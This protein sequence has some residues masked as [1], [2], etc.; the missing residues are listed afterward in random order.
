MESNKAQ[1]LREKNKR[2]AWGLVLIITG[3]VVYSWVVIKVRGKL[4]EPSDETRLQKIL[5]GL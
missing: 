5:R 4:P 3:L 1:V 2:T